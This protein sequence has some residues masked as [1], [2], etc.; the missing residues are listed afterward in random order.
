MQ[1][2]SFSRLVALGAAAALIVSAAPATAQNASDPKTLVVGTAFAS[3]SFDP[4]RGF[5]Q[6]TSMVHKA[7]YDTLVTLASNDVSQVVP[8]LA[9]SWDIS[10]DAKTFTFHLRQ[11]VKFQ[12]SGNT[13]TSTDV[14]WSIERAMGIKG[15]PSFLLDGITSIETP[16]DSTVVIH[17]SDSDPAFISKGSFAVYSVLD[18]QAV[19]AHGGT[20]GPDAATTDS[21]EQWL[22]QNSAGTGPYILTN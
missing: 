19:Q 10:P 7:T 9:T 18:S 17:K 3:K 1:R 8:D 22:D 5:E 4:A 2:R 21:A 20:S 16:D 6:T 14:K 12:T 15:N 11:G 13:M